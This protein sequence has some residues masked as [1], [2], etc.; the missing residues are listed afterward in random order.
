MRTTKTPHDS[1][2]TPHLLDSY[3]VFDGSFLGVFHLSV[4]LLSA[5]G[6]LTVFS[7]RGFIFLQRSFKSF[8]GAA[9]DFSQVLMNF[10]KVRCP[11]LQRSSLQLQRSYAL[12]VP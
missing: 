11:Q 5:F 1:R 12:W 2:F 3:P 8:C 6:G 9:I 7:L 4:L 10:R